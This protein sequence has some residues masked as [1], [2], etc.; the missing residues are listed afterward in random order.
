[1]I[2]DLG[3]CME[4]YGMAVGRDV[5]FGCWSEEIVAVCFMIALCFPYLVFPH[6][7]GEGGLGDVG[8]S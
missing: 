3:T 7:H 5:Q 6:P 2:Q 8:W 1:M 4:I